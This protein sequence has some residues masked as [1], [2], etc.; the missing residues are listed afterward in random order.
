MVNC[1]KIGILIFI[2]FGFNVASAQNQSFEQRRI[3][4][5]NTALNNINSNAIIIQAYKDIPV[6]TD[7]LQEILDNISSKSTADFDIV[8]LIRILFLTNGEYDSIILKTLEPIPFWLEKNEDNREYWSENH[9]IMWMSSDLLLHEKYGKQV[10]SNL[11]HRLKHYL[12]LKINY[13]FYEYFSSVYLP[14]CLSGLLNLADFSENIEIKNMATIAANK[15]LSDILL[16]TNSKGTYFPIAGRNYP[17]KYTSAYGQNHNNLIYLISGLGELPSNASHAGAFLATSSINLDIALNAWKPIEN[18]IFTLGHTLSDGINIINK[19]INPRDKT[20]FQWSSGAYFDPL[21]AKQT[22][23]LLKDLNLWN[24]HE[25]DDFK[26]FSGIPVALAPAIAEIG[27]VISKSSGNY[28]PTIAVYK[29]NTVTLS[30]IQDFW[31]GKNGYQQFSIVANAGTSAVF[32]LSGRPTSV[33]NDRPSIHANTH[34]PYAKQ[35]DNIALVMYRPEKGLSLF[36]YEGEK[37]YVSLYWKDD[38]FDEVK[39]SGNWIL[40]REDDG[41]VAVRRHCVNEINGVKACDNI[42]G[43]TWIYIVG[44]QGTYG[45]FENFE[46]IIN[47][48]HYEEKWYFNLP[49]LQWVYFSKIIIDGKTLEYAWN[50]DIFSGPTETTTAIA[51]NKKSSKDILVY[52]NPANAYVKTQLPSQINDNSVVRIYNSFGQEVYQQKIGIPYLKESLIET[53]NWNNGTY[54]LTL[55]TDDAIY[56][57]SFIINR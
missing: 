27:S 51:N 38:T 56:K 28:N 46:Q 29:N 1:I 16:L 18:K 37:L 13:G 40:G 32:T 52:P 4:Y 35:K 23:T 45:S 15:L 41:Y 50:G 26:A 5:N 30:S 3:Q 36:G 34:L 47:Q 20:I 24:H 57:N 9:M 39:E 8:K 6:Q 11:I 22:A 14:Y 54:I 53:S 2:F 43:Q 44:N 31:K 21:V 10:D 19:D 42:D 55:E 48:S 33:W 49:T 7:I 17:D 25:F 12:N